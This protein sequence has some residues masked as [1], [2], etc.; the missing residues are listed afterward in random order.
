MNIVEVH[1]RRTRDWIDALIASD[2][3]LSRL[4][5][6]LQVACAIGTT[7]AAEYGFVRL[8]HPFWDVAPPGVHLSPAAG[9]ALVA[10]H[11]Q[12]TLLAMLLGGIIGMIS[13]LAVTDV[14]RRGQAIT[15]MGMPVPLLAALAI[16]TELA[17]HRAIG[18]VGLALV[19]GL[20]TYLRKFAPRFGSRV[21]MYGVLLFMGYFFGFLAGSELPI[22]Q[23]YWVAAILWLAAL[24]NLALRLVVFDRVAAGA[25]SRSRRSFA[26]RARGVISEAAAVLD[27][28]PSARTRPC[29]LSRR[30]VRLNE[31][32]ITID[33]HLADPRLRLGRGEAQALHDALFKLEL[34]LENL[35]GGIGVLALPDAGLDPRLGARV[36]AWLISLAAGD[37]S[38]AAAY[39][40][41]GVS[42]E[43]VGTAL[44]TG[45]VVFA[46]A[47]TVIEVGQL[48]G[49]WQHAEPPPVDAVDEVD[50][51]T[52]YESPV[53]LVGGNLAGSSQASNAALA[54]GDGGGLAARLHLDAPAV[55]AIRVAIAVG[56][57]SAIGSAVNEKRFY[58]A[59]IA[60]FITFMGANTAGE[61]IIKAANR[62]LGTC[63]GIV[64]GSLLAHVVGPSTWSIAVILPA[65]AFGV[66]F[67]RVSY[68]L[69]VV[70]ITV[71]VSMLYV[72]L[73]EFSN[74]LLLDRLELTAI[75][76]AVAMLAALVVF[77][78]STRRVV[79][80][81]ALH[82]LD[83][84]LFLV[85]GLSEAVRGLDD[86]QRSSGT[87]IA[88]ARRLDD[89]LQQLLATAR[90][91][92]RDPFRRNELEHNLHV[93]ILGAQ[94][95]RNLAAYAD[96][97]A[98]IAL[99][100]TE[101]AHLAAALETEADLV[102]GLHE[103]IR[104]R[105]SGPGMAA[106]GSA[107]DPIVEAGRSL[108]GQGVVRSDPRRRLLRA[109]S[110]LD[111][112]LVQLGRQLA[113]AGGSSSAVSLPSHGAP[114]RTN[115][116]YPGSRARR[117]RN[118]S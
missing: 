110:N 84:L 41:E 114:H 115:E 60:V 16:S 108:A 90:P 107:V 21:V 24:L 33:A 50:F 89:T 102:R 18:L 117:T 32:A 70:G 95:A 25:L 57:A 36:R 116:M 71:M 43:T 7:I 74:G 58:W 62:V 40:Q 14:S 27:D 88:A 77:P 109:L 104:C 13:G 19:M 69:M 87:S 3:G 98:M 2:P 99:D 10:Q 79:R 37:T 78:V 22:G 101:R 47:A 103:A 55:A 113:D 106:M 54:P 76:A 111:S 96:A 91:L 65:V 100:E 4:T 23:I 15:M 59:V 17:P 44:A 11:H 92:T 48:L 97:G 72:D 86:G 80:Q 67:L 30:L 64:L 66:Y 42:D 63:V 35:G 112:A 82:Y 75:G 1:R 6:A 46:T 105:E 38:D 61:Q 20:G 68:S 52:A 9:A 8:V 29:R 34:G 51:A 31:S 5:Q 28:G 118:A 26:A 45:N 56:V 12:L 83:A 85:E 49:R 93:F 94:F 53:M 81:A 39:E 73:G